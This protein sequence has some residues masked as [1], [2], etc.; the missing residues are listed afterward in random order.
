M[1]CFTVGTLD[2]RQALQSVVQHTLND[3]DAPT[4][5]RVRC[6]VDAVNF[7]VTAT[8]GFTAGHAIVSVLDNED[9]EVGAPF[10]LTPDQC[11]E[12]LAVFKASKGL[13]EEE[14]LRVAVTKEHV[15]VTDCSGLFDGKSLSLPKTPLFEQWPDVQG[16]IGKHLDVAQV[17]D[18]QRALVL[19]NGEML[20]AFTAAARAYK[21]P[22][23]I[24][25]VGAGNPRLL[26]TCGESFIGLLM[27]MS[28]EA[29]GDHGNEILDWRLA[30]R[31]RLPRHQR[32][33][34]RPDPEPDDDDAD[35]PKGKRGKRSEHLKPV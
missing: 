7:T 14:Q 31:R 16:L 3:P 23:A 12:L 8:N 27:T 20:R 32:D 30:W 1:T 24:E 11:N 4:F 22:L 34:R 2:L 21:A 26:I 33:V 15:T 9:G 6:E 17:G 25:A 29:A 19:A 5:C 35:P 13:E 10:D 28:V 18:P